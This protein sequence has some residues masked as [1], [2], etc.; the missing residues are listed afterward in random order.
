MPGPSSAG[1]FFQ[2]FQLSVNS[3]LD[4]KKARDGQAWFNKA[5]RL[6]K[7]HIAQKARK[8]ANAIRWGVQGD[9]ASLRS[10]KQKYHA[11]CWATMKNF[12]EEHWSKLLWAGEMKNS[13]AFWSMVNDLALGKNCLLSYRINL[14][15][16][17]SHIRSLYGPANRKGIIPF[18]QKWEQLPS[19]HNNTA[20]RQALTI[21]EKDP[22]GTVWKSD[23]IVGL[24]RK[25]KP[26]GAT[27]HNGLPNAVFKIHPEY[28]AQYF[29]P[30]FTTTALASRIPDSSYT[31]SSKVETRPYPQ[32]IG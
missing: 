24:I 1:G 22:W 5:L 20:G 18:N 15:M 3:S 2:N 6:Q 23:Q 13:K 29:L 16:W 4:S 11:D 7:T 14:A 25:M 17:E 21:T 8:L 26:E 19:S 12:L 27:G 31:P 32:T 28:W 30:L 10:L 9:I